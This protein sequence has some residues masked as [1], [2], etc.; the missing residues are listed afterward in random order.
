MKERELSVRVSALLC[1]DTQNKK[2]RRTFLVRFLIAM[3]LWLIGLA[4][5]ILTDGFKPADM[6]PVKNFS[7]VQADS[8]LFK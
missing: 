2:Q 6:V 7:G 4:T 1:T 5:I 8:I 3:A